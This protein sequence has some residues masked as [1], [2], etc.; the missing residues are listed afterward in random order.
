[1]WQCRLDV[2][3]LSGYSELKFK[4]KDSVKIKRLPVAWVSKISCFLANSI[5][6]LM[7]FRDSSAASSSVSSE[8]ISAF[9]TL[10]EGSTPCRDRFVFKSIPK[11]TVIGCS[12]EEI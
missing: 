7:S 1:M 12:A 6:R 11:L 3:A 2:D 4:A 10:F 8:G 9:P 5:S